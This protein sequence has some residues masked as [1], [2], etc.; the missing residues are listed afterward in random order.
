M[1]ITSNNF[2]YSVILNLN[3]SIKFLI[4]NRLISDHHRRL[5]KRDAVRRA[6]DSR[7]SFAIVEAKNVGV[8]SSGKLAHAI[9]GDL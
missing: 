6:Q 5:T 1:I 4:L 2:V 3:L 9:Y 8:T 7:V